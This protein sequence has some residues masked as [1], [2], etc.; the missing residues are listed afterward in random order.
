MKPVIL[1]TA[2]LVLDAV[3]AA[4]TDAVLEYC[5]DPELQAYVP[6]P[7]PYTRDSA[8]GYTEGFAP[9]A[10]LL[11][12]IRE[13]NSFLGVI[14]LKV[15]ELAS[16]ELGFWLGRPHRSRG[17]MTEAARAVVDFGFDPAG[18]DLDHI[19]WCAVVG[20]I[21]S[22]R[23]ARNAGFRYEGLR[24]QAIVHRDKR[25]DAWFAGLLRTDDRT[26]QDGWP[27]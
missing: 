13:N 8:I 26:A 27:A 16:A 5:N 22:A 21:G 15:H 4:D 23:V 18:G 6:V 9:N 2:R 20:N 17:I 10:P 19:D 12:A 24:R 7:V 3:T 14:E 11:W 1:T 25:L